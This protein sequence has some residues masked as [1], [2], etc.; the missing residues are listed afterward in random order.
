MI[1]QNKILST[2]AIDW[3]RT[4]EYYYDHVKWECGIS[5]TAWLKKEFGAT[6]N[7]TELEFSTE[8]QKSWFLLRW[9]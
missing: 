5:L 8:E 3:N 9:V 6:L 4:V 7:L 1:R 2:Y